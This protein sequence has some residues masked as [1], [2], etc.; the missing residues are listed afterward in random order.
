MLARHAKSGWGQV[1]DF[2]RTLNERGEDDAKKM[3]AYL[4]ECGYLVHQIISSDAVRALTTAEMYES[5]LKPVHGLITHHDLYLASKEEILNICRNISTDDSTVML[6]GHN[7][8]MHEV[9]NY[10]A[11]GK[12]NDMPSCSVAI[13]QFDVENWAEVNNKNGDLMAF[14]YPKKISH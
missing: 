10:F 8:G 12:V 4:E 14:E 7:P 3:S 2:D 11:E 6:V 13:I 5:Q 1:Q 9:L